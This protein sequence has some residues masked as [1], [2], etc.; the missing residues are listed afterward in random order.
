MLYELLLSE[1]YWNSQAS[2]WWQ[3]NP[4]TGYNAMMIVGNDEMAMVDC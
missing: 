3:L 4:C 1:I 2:C